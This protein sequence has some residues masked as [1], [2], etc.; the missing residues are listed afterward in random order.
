MSARNG[1]RQSCVRNLVFVMMSLFIVTGLAGYAFAKSD[2]KAAEEL[3]NAFSTAAKTAMPAVVSIKVEKTVTV[4]SNLFDNSPNLNNPFDPFGDDLLKKFF[5]D[6]LPQAPRKYF[7]RGHGS[8]FIISKDG[9]ILTNNHVVGDVDKIT[10]VLQDGR[11]FENAK[12]IG[13]DPDSE[14][15][16]I[17][18]EGDNL[19]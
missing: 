2:P 10:V 5:G 18:I 12:V 15:A 14:V 6:Q 16:L 19:A 17:K 1:S 13:T 7:E 4:S 3:S 8:G 9:Y 11:N